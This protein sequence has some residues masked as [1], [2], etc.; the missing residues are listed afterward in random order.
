[1]YRVSYI[2]YY[3]C[4]ERD[5]TKG[6][7]AGNKASDI[8]RLA[9][10]TSVTSCHSVITDVPCHYTTFAQCRYNMRVPQGTHVTRVPNQTC[11]L[12][13]DYLW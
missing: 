3:L 12:Q 8:K 6:P 9:S 10:P 13:C 1:M 11:P 7:P 4:T 2:G 5:G